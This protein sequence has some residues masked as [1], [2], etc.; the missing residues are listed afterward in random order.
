LKK[1]EDK[2]LITHQ[3]LDMKETKDKRLKDS[4]D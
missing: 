3:S 1:S 4:R 2:T